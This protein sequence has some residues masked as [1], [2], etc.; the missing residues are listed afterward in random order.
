MTVPALAETP[1]RWDPKFGM[2]LGLVAAGLTALFLSLRS[3]AIEVPLPQW[4]AALVNPNPLDLSQ[5]IAWQ[6]I[7]PRIVLSI[8][9]GAAL[10]LSGVLFQ[11]MLR[12]P[13]AEPTTLGVSAG[14]SLA[15][16]FA[17]LF[18]PQI[19]E[20]AQ[21]STA[22]LGA[23]A[24][25][26]FSFALSWRS[27]SP[28]RLI[29]SGLIIS[30]FC[31][32]ANSV[33]TLFFHEHLRG[34]FL[35][36]AGSLMNVG[37]DGVDFLVPS[38]VLALML[39][40]MLARPFTLL[41]LDDESAKSLGIGLTA[42][43]LIGMVI[44]VC[45][46]AFTVSVVGIIGF[47]GIAAP[48]LVRLAGI[49]T[50]QGRIV[51]AP[52]VGGALV[53]LADQLTQVNP[54]L[55]NDLP[56]GLMT[57]VL[58]GPLMLWML[59]RLRSMETGKNSLM[60]D[61]TRR[62]SK[63][64]LAAGIVWIGLGIAAWIGLALGQSIHGWQFLGPGELHAMLEWRWPRVAAAIAAGAM[65]A[66]SGTL[67]QRLT[68]NAMASPEILGVSSG[69]TLGVIILFLV[70]ANA[71]H[72]AN[73][74]AAAFGA[75]VTLVLVLS[76]ARKAAFSPERMLLTGLAL[77]TVLSALLALLMVSGD[78]RLAGLLAWM[79][80]STYAVLPG[81]ALVAVAV[82]VGLF[83]IAPLTGRWLDVLPLGEVATR[84][85]GLGLGLSRL[86]IL[87]MSAMLTGAAV[88]IVGP[89][90]FVGLMA[91]HIARMM[92]FQRSLSQLAG[93]AALGALIMV[94]ADW[95]GRNILFPYQVPAG[96]LATLIGG[97]YFMWLMWRRPR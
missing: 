94:T 38:L 74:G 13:L 85:L 73:V 35:W 2:A 81:D 24:A 6:V 40:A 5:M 27:L 92:G 30:L 50:F 54:I 53:W 80:G 58:G 12:N 4:P 51:V 10:A 93:S 87:L 21:R 36:N 8:L 63:P 65:L 11:Q 79:A 89:L 84:E 57:A 14:A 7:L 3:I 15:L 60:A 95:L 70:N 78:R 18:A 37:W 31:G 72:A 75:F 82:A 44:A 55:P 41:D 56:T 71:G 90:S 48:A 68:G 88:L 43:R 23:L 28:V 69:A 76:M 39:T 46:A 64:W 29:L 67:M 34:V 42:I 1:G 32:V 33:L 25:L 59:P 9:A 22:L 16:K 52:M 62:L 45:L 83:A 97:P 20:A 86:V 49:R 61:A 77:G 17:V 26:A 91:P 66:M 96:I 47:I 19:A